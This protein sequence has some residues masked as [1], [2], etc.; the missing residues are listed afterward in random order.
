[1]EA[2]CLSSE[3]TDLVNL[4]SLLVL[5][6]P[7]LYFLCAGIIG[8]MP[9]LSGIYLGAWDLNIGPHSCVPIVLPTEPSLQTP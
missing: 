9:N 6:I 1:M 3:L 4:V 7:C 2:E 5:G 8:G